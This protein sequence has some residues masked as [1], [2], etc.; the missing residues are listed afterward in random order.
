MPCVLGWRVPA[1]KYPGAQGEKVPKY[2]SVN[3]PINAYITVVKNENQT[4]SW[5]EK[6]V[7]KDR[8][9]KQS[10]V[11]T[12]NLLNVKDISSVQMILENDQMKNSSVSP[13]SNPFIDNAPRF[14]RNSPKA[15][16]KPIAR[17]PIFPLML[18]S[19]ISLATPCCLETI[20]L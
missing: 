1:N 3:N 17:K 15:P 9:P 19:S 11:R 10:R 4:I 7:A 20:S 16:N 14:F 2:N 6:R 8:A 18:P 12:P 13:P 5:R